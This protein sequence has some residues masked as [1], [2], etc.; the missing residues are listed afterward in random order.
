M[1]AQAF[2]TRKV[3]ARACSIFE[4]LDEAIFDMPEKSIMVVASKVVSLC[5]GRVVAKEG[6][7]LQTL[8]RREAE[9]YMP[10]AHAQHHGYTFTVAYNMLTPNSGIDES[11]ADGD[12]VL[13]PADPQQSANDIREYLCQRFKRQDIGVVISDGSFIPLRWGSV[14]LTLAYSGFEPVRWYSEQTD[15]FGRPLRYTRTNIM[16]SLATTAT[17]LMG[18]GAEQT[19]LVLLSDLPPIVFQRRNPTAEELA[20]L[21]ASLED[22]TYAPMLQAVTWQKGGRAKE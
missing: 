6:T 20:G 15:L 10:D 11:N 18:E 4:L 21:R 14:G 22:D 9:E 1:I 13:W 7:D 2:K 3:I 19:P 16:D 17:L 5:E 12:Y 8:V